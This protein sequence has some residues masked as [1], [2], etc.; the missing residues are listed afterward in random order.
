MVANRSAHQMRWLLAIASLLLLCGCAG[1]QSAPSPPYALSDAET[2]TV[3]RG[4]YSA[5]K[6]S[7]KP[8]F[9]DLKPARITNAHLYVFGWMDSN[10]KA[11]RSPEQAFIGTLSAGRFS[12]GQIGTNASS[13]TE[14]LVECQKLGIDAED[15][16][17]GS[18]K[19]GWNNKH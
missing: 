19:S 9:R 18:V 5:A 1:I 7:D 2:T 17:G 4:I 12:L 3:E 11:Y 15:V 10:N 8:G 13:I 16:V 14:V 6:L